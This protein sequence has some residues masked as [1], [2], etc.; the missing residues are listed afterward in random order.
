MYCSYLKNKDRIVP[1]RGMRWNSVCLTLSFSGLKL[2]L[3]SSW[4]WW[5]RIMMRNVYASSPRQLHTLFSGWDCLDEDVRLV[6]A[7]V[8]FWKW[9]KSQLSERFQLF[10]I[11]LG[12][13]VGHWASFP[14]WT[15]TELRGDWGWTSDGVRLSLLLLYYPISH[16]TSSYLILY[17]ILPTTDMIL[18][19]F[20]SL[21]LHNSTPSN[22]LQTLVQSSSSSDHVWSESKVELD[23]WLAGWRKEGSKKKFL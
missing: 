4:W 17:S 12:F 7:V 19:P 18:S 16:T 11:W 15:D 14:S 21:Y 5:R 8:G 3:L 9:M 2:N 20:A 13:L 1:V 6:V 22:H 10:R 23:S